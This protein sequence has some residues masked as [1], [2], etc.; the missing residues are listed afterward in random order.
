MDGIHRKRSF[1]RF[2]G[3]KGMLQ[4]NPELNEKEV[5]PW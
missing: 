4:H 1:D 3:G 2:E 5:L